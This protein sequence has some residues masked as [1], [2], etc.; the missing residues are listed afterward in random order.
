MSLHGAQ[1]STAALQPLQCELPLR[2]HMHLL[3]GHVS[4]V[5]VKESVS[6]SY[7]SQL[8][9]DLP[10]SLPFS[11]SS[12]HFLLFP[13]SL[14]FL[15]PSNSLPLSSRSFSGAVRAVAPKKATL[16]GNHTSGREAAK[17][18]QQ[19]TAVFPQLPPER[20]PVQWPSCQ[21]NSVRG[22]QGAIIIYNEL[23]KATA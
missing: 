3:L 17:A 16:R 4:L 23:F 12:L 19:L 14:S 5:G 18:R 7:W 20:H 22:L 13:L 6:G 9:T 15:T 10:L 8:M 21:V 11:F 1:V 2:S